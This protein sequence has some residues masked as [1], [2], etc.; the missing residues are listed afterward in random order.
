LFWRLTL[1]EIGVILD[2]EAARAKR[3]RSDTAWLAW[4]TAA[5]QRVKKFPKLKDM[6]PS[7]P[8][9]PHVQTVAEQVAIAKAWTAALSRRK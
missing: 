4:H 1:R 9:K 7:A 6:L 8:R 3:Q 5:L 2:G